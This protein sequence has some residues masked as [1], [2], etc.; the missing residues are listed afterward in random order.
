MGDCENLRESPELNKYHEKLYDF[1]DELCEESETWRFW[2]S[3]SSMIETLLS[4]MYAILFCTQFESINMLLSMIVDIITYDRRNYG[5]Y[6]TFNYI[7]MINLEENH[8]W[9]YQ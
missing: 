7:E 1:L 2:Q 3:V 8:P 9:I 4:I 5:R 6:L